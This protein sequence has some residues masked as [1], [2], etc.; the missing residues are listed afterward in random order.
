MKQSVQTKTG[1]PRESEDDISDRL[2]ELSDGH[3]S[4]QK[5]GTENVGAHSILAGLGKVRAG[6]MAMDWVCLRP[7]W[8]TFFSFVNSGSKRRPFFLY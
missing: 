5:N 6:A 8:Q 4:W 3:S 1:I 7:A 2:N